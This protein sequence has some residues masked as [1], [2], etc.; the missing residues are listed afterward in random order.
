MT[1][2]DEVPARALAVYAHPDDPEV[3]CGGTLAR[4]AA[5]GAEVRVVIAAK[6]EKGSTDPTT[7][8]RALAAQRAEEVAAA[9]AALGLAGVELLGHPDGELD[10]AGPSA[11]RAEIVALV[12][13]FTPDTVVCPD[14]TAVFFGD[15]YV[16]HVDH[17]TIGWATLDAVAPAAG[18]PLYFPDRGPAH[19]VATLLLSGTLEPDSWVD[20]EA[21]LDAKVA[22]LFAHRSQLAPDAEAWLRDFV[23][24]RAEVEGR[25]AGVAFAESFRRL[26]FGRE[27]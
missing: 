11:L 23:R 22:A 10:A 2:L 20:I 4:W 8:P 13:R 12:R 25:R 18:S 3:S 24:H 7:D 14:P 19:Q 21:N 15:G 26:R 16:S 6:G 9:A 5:A 27:L 17:R 1:L